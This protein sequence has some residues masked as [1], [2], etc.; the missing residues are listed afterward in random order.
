VV[1]ESI[2]VTGLGGG[3]SE[4]VQSLTTVVNVH[5]EEDEDLDKDALEA[6]RDENQEE[7]S[8]MADMQPEAVAQVLRTWLSDPRR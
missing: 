6:L 3:S 7:L 8:K 5:D 4:N 1:V 2:D